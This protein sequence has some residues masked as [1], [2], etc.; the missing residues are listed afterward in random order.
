MWLFVAEIDVNWMKLLMPCGKR[1][2]AK[3]L[4]VSWPI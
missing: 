4:M 2:H 1:Q 3:L